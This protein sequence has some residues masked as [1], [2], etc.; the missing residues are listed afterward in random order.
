MASMMLCQLC[1][2]RSPLSH[3]V[4]YAWLRALVSKTAIALMSAEA[5]AT[6]CLPFQMTILALHDS[7]HGMLQGL[8]GVSNTAV[9]LV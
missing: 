3:H 4:A 2:P 8:A 6:T 9:A 7:A 1:M 5:A